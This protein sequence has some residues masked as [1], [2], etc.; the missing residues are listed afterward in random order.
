MAFAWLFAS[1]AGTYSAR[2][3]KRYFKELWFSF[4]IF[5]QVAT[6]LSVVTGASIMFFN[7]G[8]FLEKSSHS[9]L[10]ITF[11]ILAILG[12][13]VILLALAQG[14]LGTYSHKS[15]IPHRDVVPFF[16]FFIHWYLGHSVSILG[17]ANVGVGIFHFFE[18]SYSSTGFHVSSSIFWIW[19]AVNV[20]IWVVSN[21][22]FPHLVD[23]SNGFVPISALGKPN[24]GYYLQTSKDNIFE[25][26][27][28][29]GFSDPVDLWAS[30]VWSVQLVF[31]FLSL[32]IL[33]IGLV[34]A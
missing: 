19:C 27:E 25:S 2:Y 17:A 23:L 9:M 3:L 7:Y 14:F 1:Q 33:I 6:L 28:E 5:F 8:F 4:H 24:L 29:V 13:I 21:F 30:R 15:W 20:V 11:L 32:V 34:I 12:T 16:F 18:G 10:H 31:N 22:K 26:E